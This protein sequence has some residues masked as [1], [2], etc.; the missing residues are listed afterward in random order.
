MSASR[1]AVEVVPGRGI[2]GH[3]AE[4]VPGRESIHGHAVEVVPEN[5]KMVAYSLIYLL[6]NA[7]THGIGAPLATAATTTKMATRAMA[8]CMLMMKSLLLGCSTA[9]QEVRLKG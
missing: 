2:H 8:L 3:A 5:G 1:F 9:W 7:I 6:K 4:V